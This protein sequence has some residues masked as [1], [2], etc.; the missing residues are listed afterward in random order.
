MLL[1]LLSTPASFS[2]LC[3]NW[4]NYTAGLRKAA[5][6]SPPPPPP[7]PPPPLRPP[8]LPFCADGG[9]LKCRRAPCWKSQPSSS[10]QHRLTPIGLPGHRSECTGWV[11][12]KMA[13][14][15]AGYS[16]THGHV[17]RWCMRKK[18]E[19][20]GGGG[21]PEC[22]GSANDAAENSSVSQASTAW[23]E[24]EACSLIMTII[25]LLCHVK[26]NQRLD[27]TK[28]PPS[29]AT[30]SWLPPGGW[31]QDRSLTLPSPC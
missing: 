26:P 14:I 10:A 5:P 3:S 15:S 31:Q 6:S 17:S 11:L 8:V 13:D 7:P 19:K 20:D 29:E 22:S 18:R 4:V 25:E 21:S 28:P 9:D 24:T 27:H 23:P 30:A 12:T 2:P 16:N 1:L